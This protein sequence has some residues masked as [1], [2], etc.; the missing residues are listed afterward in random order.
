VKT[1][2]AFILFVIVFLLCLPN[3]ALA[4]P[5]Y[6]PVR[7]VFESLGGSVEQFGHSIVIEQK[8]NKIKIR[9]N[10]SIA[11]KNG[12]EVKLY[13]P[14]IFNDTKKRFEVHV[15]DVYT[16]AK[17][18]DKEKHYRVRPGDTLSGIAKR[19]GATVS[20]LK[21][22]NHLPSTQ[23]F[24]GQHLHVANPFYTVKDGE[25]LWEIAER[26]EIS[27]D[28]IKQANDLHSDFISTGQKLYI[29]TQPSMHPP[30]MFVQGFF[31]LIDDTYQ[32]YGNDFDVSRSYSD[33]ETASIH[34]GIDIIAP[35][36]VPVFAA[37]EGKVREIGWDNHDG[38]RILIEASNGIV[39]KY[40]HLNGF[41][42]GLKQGQQV[43]RGQLIGY[44]G[45]TGNGP[46]GT[47]GK[48]EPHLHVGMY[49]TNVEPWKPL[50]AYYFLKWWEMR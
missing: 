33:Q 36:W 6:V 37:H 23:L 44:V 8:D 14:I 38:W 34:E 32:P 2:R 12:K 42:E 43:S 7:N 48:Y 27:V 24:V 30:E 1:A 31:P 45:D 50:N 9:E 28:E 4:A 49:D 19:F 25:S 41:P 13:Q 18:E 3:A 40:A 22:W 20:G 26:N 47:K 17:T 46:K 16:L 11:E 5:N 35:A 21:E 29:P 10:S 39:L 15:L